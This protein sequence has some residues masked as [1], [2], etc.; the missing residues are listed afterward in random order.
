VNMI[1]TA[2]M[3]AIMCFSHRGVQTSQV[4]D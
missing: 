2:V 4:Q 3:Y 1:D